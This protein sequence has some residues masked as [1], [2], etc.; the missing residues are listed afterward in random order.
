[1]IKFEPMSAKTLNLEP[2]IYR[3]PSYETTLKANRRISNIEPQNFEVWYRAAQSFFQS[4]IRNPKS[5]IE[6][7]A[8]R[9]PAQYRIKSWQCQNTKEKNR[10]LQV[11]L[12]NLLWTAIYRFFLT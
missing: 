6:R 3:P 1:M 12:K 10:H 9:N 11:V 7:P 4:A 2:W 8:S 5:A